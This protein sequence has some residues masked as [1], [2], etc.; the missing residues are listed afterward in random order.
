MLF[1]VGSDLFPTSSTACTPLSY[2]LSKI[3]GYA[4]DPTFIRLS[5]TSGVITVF[6]S[7]VSKVGVYKFDLVA[8]YASPKPSAK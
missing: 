1:I 2:K 6:T 8:F 5:S 4:F 3:S 7:D